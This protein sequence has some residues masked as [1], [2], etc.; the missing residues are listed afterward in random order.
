[1]KY[2]IICQRIKS[3]RFNSTSIGDTQHVISTSARRNKSWSLWYPQ[4]IWNMQAS[5]STTHISDR[6]WQN[7]WFCIITM[8]TCVGGERKSQFPCNYWSCIVLKLRQIQ[9]RLGVPFSHK[10]TQNP[11]V[12]SRVVCQMKSWQHTYFTKGVNR[13]LIEP[14]VTIGWTI[15]HG[16]AFSKLWKPEC[17]DGTDMTCTHMSRK[18]PG[19]KTHFYHPWN[20]LMMVST[21]LH[22]QDKWA[23]CLFGSNVD[24]KTKSRQCLAP[25]CNSCTLTLQWEG[26][27]QEK[28]QNYGLF[29]P[30]WVLFCGYFIFD[31]DSITV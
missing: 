11:Q 29:D 22:H 31:R 20:N 19:S 5:F 28:H 26:Q 24:W 25:H 7:L 4:A 1:M 2:V 12:E 6:I 3:R 13:S 15:L 17:N 10:W 9:N 30:F 14:V 16:Q 8:F 21:I 23:S 18:L 27:S